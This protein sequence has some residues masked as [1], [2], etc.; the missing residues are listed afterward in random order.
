M[1]LRQS[2]L[3]GMGWS[4]SSQLGRQIVQ[5][6][7]MIIL[8]KLLAPADFGIVSMAAV[9]TGF[10][11]IFNDLGM[12]AA[13]IQKQEHSAE[14]LTSVFWLNVGFAFL[15]M[16][17]VMV[18]APVASAFYREPELYSVLMAMSFIFPIGSMV[19]LQKALLERSMRF[20]AIAIM[21][22]A[23]TLL[24]GCIAIVVAFHD[25]GV[26]SLVVQALIASIVSSAMIWVYSTWRPT[27]KFDFMEF[28]SI[29]GF[30]A[31]LTATN[32]FNYL[33]RNADSI[34]IGRFL[35]AQ[36]LG[37]YSLAYRI[38]MF[39]V[40]NMSALVGRVMFPVFSKLQ[41]DDARFRHIFLKSLEAVALVSFPLMSLIFV[42]AGEFI[43]QVFGAKWLPVASL[44]MIFAPVGLLQSIITMTG[45][46]YLSKGRTDLL[47]RWGVLSGTV[48][49]ASFVLGLQ[50]GIL[51]V[52]W[53]YA[54]ATVLLL[55]PN[56]RISCGLVN[57]PIK[58]ILTVLWPPFLCAAM[59]AMFVWC[60]NKP[61]STVISGWS[62]LVANLVIAGVVYFALG[63]FLKIDQIRRVCRLLCKG[64][65]V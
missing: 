42:L 3:H 56:L 36:D 19:A 8:A 64:G 7:V 53:C 44:L 13:V 6:V 62:L 15:V 55:Y 38:L 30:S 58:S 1:A 65:V 18:I 5:F 24:A 14:L 10:A 48:A 28:K 61:M 9:I 2:I 40:Q 21:E 45:L 17:L 31:N 22:L 25:G 46:I 52:A 60:L 47:F 35:G 16:I 11:A 27:L 54:M 33:A 51:G 32:I 57:L 29:W 49:V 37:Y 59:M 23:T 12:S 63:C 39:P 20:K 43:H 50:W 26:W 41:N 34:I 4:A